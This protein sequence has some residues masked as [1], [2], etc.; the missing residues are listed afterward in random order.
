MGLLW[1]FRNGCR[2]SNEIF[3][4]HIDSVHF[5]SIHKTNFKMNKFSEIECQ[6]LFSLENDTS[7]LQ[8]DFITVPRFDAI[9][10]GKRKSI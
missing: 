2:F 8:I 6:I 4:P 3:S 5:K 1:L 10:N 7:N 9:V